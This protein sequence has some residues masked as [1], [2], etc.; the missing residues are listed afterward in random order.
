MK[1]HTLVARFGPTDIGP[2]VSFWPDSLKTD[3]EF[4]DLT[5]DLKYGVSA[6]LE[7]LATLGL[8]PTEA[9]LDLVLLAAMVFGADT[10]VPRK[11]ESQDGW[12]RE[13]EINL[14]SSRILVVDEAGCN[15]R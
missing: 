12:T 8:Q 14:G 2:V 1:R 13:M 4:L 3:V 15:S 11:T 10:R 6:S 9:A 7:K 5:G